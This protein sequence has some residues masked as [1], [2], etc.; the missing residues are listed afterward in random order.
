MASPTRRA[1]LAGAASGALVG[2][3]GCLGG[4]GLSCGETGAVLVRRSRVVRVTVPFDEPDATAAVA[5]AIESQGYTVTVGVDH[6][7]GS[8]DTRTI[9]VLGDLPRAEVERIAA[10]EGLTVESVGAS[11]TGDG[12]F[13]DVDGS[14][15]SP[16]ATPLLVARA[17][18]YR[19]A[20]TE[21]GVSVPDVRV[22]KTEIGVEAPPDGSVDRAVDAIRTAFGPSGRV[23]V[24]V[25]FPD[26]D[27]STPP[28]YHFESGIGDDDVLDAVAYY[29]R[30]DT[31]EIVVSARGNKFI[32]SLFG[33]TYH[34]RL[35]ESIDDATVVIRADG[36]V[37]QRR[38]PTDLERAYFEWYSEHATQP[39]D[40]PYVHLEIGG[41]SPSDAARI[42]AGI[43]VPTGS[44]NVFRRRC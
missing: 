15:L 28:R 32:R 23:S 38:P 44:V 14:F 33:P 34:T 36:D 8:P 1:L 22:T 30:G 29:R 25:E 12:P 31:A 42:G 13:A 41:L 3:A 21:L 43:A 7:Y 19:S 18:A 9:R 24:H 40:L 39:P 37:I 20:A 26:R 6:A 4:S 27:P 17:D 35:P 11:T 16:W 5:A 2:N 10:A